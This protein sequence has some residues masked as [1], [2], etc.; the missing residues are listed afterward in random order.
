M[1]QAMS[2]DILWTS[3]DVAAALGVGVSSVKR[4]TDEGRLASVRTPGGHR[5]YEISAVREFAHA[6]GYASE[7]LPDLPAPPATGVV[8]LRAALLPALLQGNAGTV[9]AVVG[10][11]RQLG[12]AQVLD[13]AVSETL[14]T[15]GEMWARGELGVEAEHQAS[16]LLSEA[17][18]RLRP[19]TVE[20]NGPLAILA[21]PPGEQHELPLRMVRLLVE[22]HAWRTLY[23]GANTPW[24]AVDT[25]VRRSKPA[26]VLLSARSA[27]PFDSDRFIELCRSWRRMRVVVAIGGEWARGGSAHPAGAIRFRTLHGFEKWLK[28]R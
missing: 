20:E 26:A 1:L 10:A 17:I 5:R 18:D 8:E 28:R 2:T 24:P 16:Y 21:A 25:L 19:E 13:G 11:A 3:A 23:V 14:R 4:W 15:I 27:E 12:V 7:R 9:R 22:L 6:Y